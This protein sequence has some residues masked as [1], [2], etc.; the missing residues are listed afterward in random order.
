MDV[1]EGAMNDLAGLDD[2]LAHVREVGK[3]F[4]RPNS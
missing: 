1:E 3:I 2:R 4:D